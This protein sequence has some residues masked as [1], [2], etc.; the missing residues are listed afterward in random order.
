[1]W[2]RAVSP[3]CTNAALVEEDDG[4]EEEDE[5]PTSTTEHSRKIGLRGEPGLTGSS[6]KMHS[7]NASEDPPTPV[8]RRRRGLYKY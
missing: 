3:A 8:T 1:M 5:L 6:G 7:K 4:E 2:G